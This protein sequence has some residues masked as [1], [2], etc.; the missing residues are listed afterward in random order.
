MDLSSDTWDVVRTWTY[1][2][3]GTLGKQIIRAVDS[4]PANIAEGYGRYTFRERVRFCH[5][6]RGSLFEY[7]THLTIGLRRGLISQEKHDELLQNANT[8]GRLL[9][10]FIRHLTGQ[11]APAANVETDGAFG[12]RT[13]YLI[14]NTQDRVL[15]PTKSSTFPS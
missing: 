7:K 12:L 3:K 2:H 8:I 4:I 14:P 9:N 1:F 15:R 11:M 13:Q 5:F 6:A 10:G